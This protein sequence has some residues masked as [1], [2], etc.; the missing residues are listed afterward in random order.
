MQRRELLKMS[1]LLL[2]GSVSAS[3][4]QALLAGAAA[5]PGA[6]NRFNQAQAA[7]VRL[8]CDMIIP[9]TDTPGAVEAGVPDF[10]ATIVFDWYRP[11]ERQVFLK[12]LA[13]LD[14][15]ARSRQRRP[16][17]RASERTRTAALEDAVGTPFFRALKELVVHG[18]YTSEVGCTQEMIYRPAPGTYDGDVDFADVGRRWFYF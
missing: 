9:Q 13:A 5:T 4:S 7:A 3:L 12:G 1:A 16:F 6:V 15:S 10:V 2:G 17:H 18:Y 8:L 11:N 14:E